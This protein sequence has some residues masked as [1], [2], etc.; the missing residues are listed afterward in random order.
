MLGLL[1]QRMNSVTDPVILHDLE[2]KY[3]ALW[4]LTHRLPYFGAAVVGVFVSFESVALAIAMV[5][6]LY[7]IMPE[8]NPVHEY[9]RSRGFRP[10]S[11]L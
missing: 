9:W 7:V 5:S 4:A 3:D 11:W 2:R 6:G 8:K 10:P 1:K